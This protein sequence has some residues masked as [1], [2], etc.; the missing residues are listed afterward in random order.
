MK[1]S[2]LKI[3]LILCLIATPGL[4]ADE[5]TGTYGPISMGHTLYP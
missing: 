3:G 5:V 2:I 4:A 1:I